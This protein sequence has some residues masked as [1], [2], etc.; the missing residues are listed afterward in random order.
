MM[1]R[2]MSQLEYLPL[3][4]TRIA[5]VTYAEAVELLIE[6]AAAGPAHAYASARANVHTV[7]MARRKRRTS[8]AC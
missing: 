4:G 8:G 6:K 1:A 3:L 7:S 2:E 5:S